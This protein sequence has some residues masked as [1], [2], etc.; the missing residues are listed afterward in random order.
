VTW[1]PRTATYLLVRRAVA[2]LAAANARRPWNPDEH[3]HRR[4]LRRVPRGAR[5]VLPGARV[6][7]RLVFRFTFEWTRP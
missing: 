4:V 3:L 6:R 1:D 2:A 5:A 7:R